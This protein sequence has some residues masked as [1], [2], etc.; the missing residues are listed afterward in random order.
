MY[1]FYPVTE[2]IIFAQTSFA[3]CGR[4]NCLLRSERYSAMTWK[5]SHSLFLALLPFPLR[6]RPFTDSSQQG[7]RAALQFA[8]INEIKG[9]DG[10]EPLYRQLFALGGQMN[11]ESKVWLS[12]HGEGW[13]IV[14]FLHSICLGIRFSFFSQA[15]SFHLWPQAGCSFV[16]NHH[17]AT[18]WLSFL[19]ST[20]FDLPQ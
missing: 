14:F 20:C 6:N 2:G 5:T 1:T 10:S 12:L 16:S 7:T 15:F 8:T 4:K 18:H 13:Q 19:L 3:L 9:R 11:C 17:L